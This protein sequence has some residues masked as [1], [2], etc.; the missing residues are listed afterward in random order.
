MSWETPMS[1]DVGTKIDYKTEMNETYHPSLCVEPPRYNMFR[2]SDRDSCTQIESRVLETCVLG[3]SR[4]NLIPFSYAQGS[5][6]RAPPSEERLH[7]GSGRDCAKGLRMRLCSDGDSMRLF[8]IELLFE[9]FEK[10][11]R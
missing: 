3:A 11:Q 6:T 5:H 8:K 4:R 1:K 7:V 2:L 9:L 10:H